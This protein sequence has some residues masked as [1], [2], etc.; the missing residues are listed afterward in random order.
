MTIGTG[1]V[2]VNTFLT[3]YYNPDA[4]QP[5]YD[6]EEAKRLLDDAGYEPDA[7]GKRFSLR[8]PYT[9]AYFA[10]EKEC[11][12]IKDDLAAV[13]IEVELI[14]MEDPTFHDAVFVRWDFDMCII[15]TSSGADPQLISRYYNGKWI[16]N[17]SWSNNARYNNSEVNALLDASETEWD[18]TK[19][20]ELV[21]QASQIIVDEMPSYWMICMKY[22]SCVN[23]HFKQELQ[24]PVAFEFSGGFG[25]QRLEGVY[26]DRGAD[27]PPWVTPATTTTPTTPE[28][29]MWIGVVLIALTVVPAAYSVVKSKRKPQ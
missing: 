14:R 26:D 28:F 8:L 21:K 10:H 23:T 13:G 25:G 17:I 20:G 16:K 27:T 11:E 9:T 15:A 5:G 22:T 2:S 3:W 6:P 7:N 4:Q 12:L 24:S 19:R 1:P 18:R 29:S